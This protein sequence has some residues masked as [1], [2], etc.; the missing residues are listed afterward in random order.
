MSDLTVSRPTSCLR[1]GADIAGRASERLPTKSVFG[2]ADRPA[3]ADI[4]RGR[5]AVGFLTDDDVALLGAQHVHRLGAVGRDAERL[6][7][8][9]TASQTPRHSLPAH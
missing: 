8:S 5:R 4:V 9:N 6:P 7:A 1:S 2:L 3:E